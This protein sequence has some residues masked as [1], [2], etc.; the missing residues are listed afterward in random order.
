MSHKS[1]YYWSKSRQTRKPSEVIGVCSSAKE[2]QALLARGDDGV[3][4]AIKKTEDL[5][6]ALC[7]I[8]KYL[9]CIVRSRAQFWTRKLWEG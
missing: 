3:A 5:F 8:A 1:S 2:F 9:R 7:C 4:I 6:E